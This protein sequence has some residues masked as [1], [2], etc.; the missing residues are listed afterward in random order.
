RRTLQQM[1]AKLGA[2]H[3]TT[4][5]CAYAVADDLVELGRGSEALPIIDDC[6][7]RASRG[8]V[9]DPRLLPR[10]L[11]L[12]LRYFEKTHDEASCRQTPQTWATLKRGDAASL[13]R[14]ARMRA[15]TAAVIRASD[16]S[17]AGAERADAEADRAMAWLE[18]AAVAGGSGDLAGAEQ[19][20]DLDALRDR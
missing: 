14:A 4:L 15:V 7:E 9:V 16:R 5:L 12:R 19:D 17:P 6:V 10:V 13:S 3:P 1:K 18:Q 20:R 11:N 2:D 8:K